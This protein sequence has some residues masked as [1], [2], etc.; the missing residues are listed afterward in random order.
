MS[1]KT[2]K[3]LIKKGV[4]T[5]KRKPNELRSV[6]IDVGILEKA[7]GSAYLEWGNN[8][9]LVGIYGPREIHPRRRV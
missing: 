1:K 3:N 4:R 7:D 5:D 9:V 6:K 8:K 2:V